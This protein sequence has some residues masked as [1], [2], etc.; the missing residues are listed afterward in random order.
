MAI[1]IDEEKRPFP[2][3]P[4]LIAAVILVALV[5]GTYYLFFAAVPGIE[6]VLPPALKSANAISEID[7]E[8]SR[9]INSPEFRALRVY[10]GLPSTGEL[11]K[12]NPFAQ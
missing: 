2:W 8:P 3:F 10:T 6:V 9:V 4:L 5:A 7:V 1:L 11:G 12:A